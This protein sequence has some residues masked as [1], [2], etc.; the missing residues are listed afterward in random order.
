MKWG[1]LVLL[2]G[3]SGCSILHGRGSMDL[4]NCDPNKGQQC[5]A[6]SVEVLQ[7]MVV[8]YDEA[9]RLRAAYKFCK[10]GI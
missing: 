6:I 5:M 8:I 7:E 1:G 10:D 2:L 3:L 9:E 4:T